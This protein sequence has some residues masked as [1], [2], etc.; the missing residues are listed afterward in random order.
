M[1]NKKREKKSR[2]NEKGDGERKRLMRKGSR[3]KCGEEW[4]FKKQL[5]FTFIE[6]RGKGMK[7]NGGVDKKLSATHAHEYCICSR[8]VYVPGM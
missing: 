2:Q 3:K 4:M 7:R 8:L 6:G 5:Q 1:R